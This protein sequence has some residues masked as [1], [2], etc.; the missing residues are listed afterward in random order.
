VIPWCNAVIR[1]EFN[2]QILWTKVNSQYK[3]RP[4]L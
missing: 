1:G 2:F 3:K 4:G